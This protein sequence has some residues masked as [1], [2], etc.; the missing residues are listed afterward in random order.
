MLNRKFWFGLFIVV[1]L[2]LSLNI[3][4]ISLARSVPAKGIRE[5]RGVWITNVDSD[6]LF[7]RD[8]LAT[9]MK[10]LRQLN[11]NTIYPVVW[12]WG[13]TIYPSKVAKRVVGSSFMP[14]KSAGILIGRTLTKSE[15]LEG[16]DVLK[17][18]VNRGHKQGLAVIPWFEF[19]FMAPATSDPAGS[20]LA[21]L[22]PDWLT[23]KQDGGTIW[24]EGKDPRVWLNPFKPE[25]KKFII[26][27]VVE[28]ARKYDVDG[29]QFDDH[30]GLP[31]EFGYD[32]FTV[33]LYKKEHQG[34][35]PPT[36]PKNEEWINWR[37]DKITL[38]MKDLFLAIKAVKPKAIVSISPNPQTFAK[39][40]FLQDWATWERKG[41]VEE[42]LIQ[43]YRDKLETFIG[44]MQKPEV[45]LA[46]QHI[47]VGIGILTGVKPKPIPMK[48]IQTQIAAVRKEGL[49]GVSFFFYETLWKLTNEP[50]AARKE[51]FKQVFT[52]SVARSTIIK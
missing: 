13:Y 23:Q 45:K 31:S 33:D 41:Y 14:K 24:K 18:L 20:D 2:I 35:L 7:T 5:I 28:V 27:L 12:N 38:L 22:H 4:T 50:A 11:F 39:S 48:Q 32:K 43:L 9:A 49:A 1:G 44:E 26:D 3:P 6:V 51:G 16:R 30:F 17:E 52:Q 40:F 10:D 15:G 42:L 29:I 8:R 37:A 19:G 25:V 36:D 34:K 46:S 47:P 21:K